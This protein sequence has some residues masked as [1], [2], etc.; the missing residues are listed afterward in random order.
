MTSGELRNDAGQGE[1]RH[2]SV[3]ANADPAATLPDD[4][5]PHPNDAA[6]QNH[7]DAAAAHHPTPDAVAEAVARGRI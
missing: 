2:G 5:K 4:V 6:A 1:M 3:N 7:Q